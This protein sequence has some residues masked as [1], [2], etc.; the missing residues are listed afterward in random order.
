MKITIYISLKASIL[1]PQGEAIANALKSLG[2]DQVNSVRQG[3]I[4][5]IDL[6]ETD[7]NHGR[8]IAKKMCD[9][10]LVNNVIENF[11]ISSE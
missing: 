1:D 3:K 10:L 11:S 5:E 8:E 6:K 7:H 2:F 4:I 9:K